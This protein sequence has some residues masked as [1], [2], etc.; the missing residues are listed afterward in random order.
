MLAEQERDAEIA[1]AESAEKSRNDICSEATK[2]RAR[3]SELEAK[4]SGVEARANLAGEARDCAVRNNSE[5][6]RWYE[7]LEAKLAAAEESVKRWAL[8]GGTDAENERARADVARRQRA[9]TSRMFAG[10][11]RDMMTGAQAA[12]RVR[13][14]SLVTEAQQEEKPNGAWMVGGN[15][16]RL[17]GQL[18]VAYDVATRFSYQFAQELIATEIASWS[19]DSESRLMS[20]TRAEKTGICSIY[21]DR[22]TCTRLGLAESF[23]RKS[24]GEV[25]ELFTCEEHRGRC[26]D[27]WEP[28]APGGKETGQ[29]PATDRAWLQ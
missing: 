27:Q 16:N 13:R 6:R 7:A 19:D 15:M 2:L 5:W 1:Q 26:N 24:D 10:N 12:E 4:L 29:P 9:A 17:W 23:R 20:Q 25:R 11:P 18:G 14:M 28:V 3:V 22:G 8:L 21:D